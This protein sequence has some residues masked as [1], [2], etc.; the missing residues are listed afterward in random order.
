MTV[1]DLQQAA[2][3]HLWLHFTRMGG[4][5]RRRGADHR[6]RRRLL[7]RGRERQPLPRRAR[8]PV[9]RQHRLLVRRGDRPGGARADARA[10]LLHQLVVRPSA[11]HR[12]GR[13]GRVARARRPQPRVLRLRRLGGGRVRLE[14][15]APVLPARGERPPLQGDRRGGSPTTA[16][17][18]APC[19]STASRRCARRS[20]RSCPRCGTSQHE[21]LPPPARGDRGGVH[22]VPARRARGDDPDDGARDGLPGAS[23]SRCRTR[24]ALPPPGGLLAGRARALRPLRHPALAPTR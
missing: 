11:R 17:R 7:P 19:R 5:P 10:A 24:A 20:S 8:R 15:R 22:R 4:V 21:P 2:R 13:G 14:A 9:L 23:W 18:W 3:D 12:A 1:T 16:R 6:A